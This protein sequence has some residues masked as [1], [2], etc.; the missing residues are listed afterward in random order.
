MAGAAAGAA[1]AAA[2]GG[3]IFLGAIVGGLSGAAFS[4]I[5]GASFSAFKAFAP[6]VKFAAFGTV[7]GI[8][9]VIGGGKFGHGFLPQGL[10]ARLLGR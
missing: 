9:S 2:T 3:N 8:T 4:G 1:G 5:A 10:V 6:V 7:G